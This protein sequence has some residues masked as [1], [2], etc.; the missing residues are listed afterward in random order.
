[1]KTTLDLPDDLVQAL[2][3]RSVHERRKIKDVAAS[4]L[5]RG[6]RI[7]EAAP[8]EPRKKHIRLPFFESEADAP[9]VKMSAEELVSL[10]QKIIEEE[11][12][13]R[14]GLAL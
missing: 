8:R 3:L 10:E 5:R 2:K 11:D 9:A 12:M 13:K 6:L 4:A 1:M 7:K 14:A